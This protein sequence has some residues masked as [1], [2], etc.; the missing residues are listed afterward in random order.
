MEVRL[1]HRHLEGVTVAGHTEFITA[2]PGPAVQLADAD[3]VTVSVELE[4]FPDQPWIELWKRG[5]F[6]MS[7]EEPRFHERK[8]LV[9]TAEK[10][11]MHGAW[12]A[13]KTRV[14]ATNRAYAEEVIPAREAAARRNQAQA[15]V[16][17]AARE[18]A[19][20]LVDDL[21]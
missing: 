14:K 3:T 15:D 10:K 4:P 12:D 9:F 6:P 8:W 17:A 21:E 20:R 13:I 16:G 5:S 18:E 2:G 1:G 11:D 7:L 19:Q